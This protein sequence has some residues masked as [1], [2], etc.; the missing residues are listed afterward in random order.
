GFAERSGAEAFVEMSWDQALDLV[1]GELGRVK[2]DFGN[3]AIFDGS[4]GWASAGRFHHAQSQV[5]HFFNSIGGFV[6]HEDD[7]SVGAALV[8]MPHVVAPLFELLVTHTSWEAL[9]RECQLFVAFGGVP[10]K[11]AQIASGGAIVDS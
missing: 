7:Y 9:A 8:L 3:E 11:N 1:A 5:R 6:R 10:R 2:G 4:Y